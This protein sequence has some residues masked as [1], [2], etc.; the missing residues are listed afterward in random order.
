MAEPQVLV[1]LQQRIWIE[2]A[3]DLL[4]CH[5]KVDSGALS[6]LDG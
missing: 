1:L 4:R 6:V 2:A 5:I 3:I